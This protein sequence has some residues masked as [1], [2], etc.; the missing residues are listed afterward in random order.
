VD[1]KEQHVGTVSA[2]NIRKKSHNNVMS[3]D[4]G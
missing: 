2:A 3:E 4:E 1:I